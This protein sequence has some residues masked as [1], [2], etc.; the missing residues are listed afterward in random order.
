MPLSLAS[1][2]VRVNNVIFGR[3]NGEGGTTSTRTSGMLLERNFR[4][5]TRIA[6]AVAK[7]LKKIV[8][9]IFVQQTVLSFAGKWWKDTPGSLSFTQVARSLPFP[10]LV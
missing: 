7:F 8:D 9:F 4:V 5:S 3:V 1:T 10:R 6:V 2:C